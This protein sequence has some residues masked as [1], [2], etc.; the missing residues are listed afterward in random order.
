MIKSYK[1]RPEVRNDATSELHRPSKTVDSTDLEADDTFFKLS[2][3]IAQLTKVIYFLNAKNED[4]STE[5]SSLKEAYEDEITEILRDA[6]ERL[7]VLKVDN[8][9]KSAKLREQ[10]DFLRATTVQLQG[11]CE[12]KIKECEEALENEKLRLNLTS[13]QQIIEKD[14]QLDGLKQKLVRL[15]RERD[16]LNSIVTNDGREK[17]ELKMQCDAMEREIVQLKEATLRENTEKEMLIYEHSEKLE[18]STRE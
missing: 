2:K 12:A 13:R 1:S 8:D 10:D 17:A 14:E 6:K 9:E 18:K 16:Q 7:Q 3:K 11:A 5:M 15:T 4:H